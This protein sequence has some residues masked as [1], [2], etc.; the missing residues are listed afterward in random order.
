MKLKA[1]IFI[2]FMMLS[3]TV[4]SQYPPPAGQEG[5][6]AIHKD[7]L[8]FVN[9]ATG[10]TVQ[11]GPMDISEPGTGNASAGYPEFATSKADN[12]AVSLGDGGMA[13]LTF[14][15]PVVNG[16]GPDF[17]VFENGFQ[18]DFLELA[19]VEV[20]SN[21]I[22]FFRFA[23]VSL[24]QTDM[25][26]GAFGVLDATKI[27][28]LAGKYRVEYGVPFDLADLPDEPLL[29]KQ[30][31]THIRIADVVGSID[32]DYATYDSQGNKVN[33]PWPTPFESSGFDLDAVGVI[34]EATQSVRE[35]TV[36]REFIIYP[37]PVSDILFFDQKA[38]TEFEIRILDVTG[39]ILLVKKFTKTN[40]PSE[41]AIGQLENGFYLGTAFT[42]DAIHSFKFLKY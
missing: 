19:F 1:H 25:Q 34:H 32:D 13:I 14:E 24:T 33:E 23:A 16:D 28:N 38:F 9:W 2:A 8:V 18:D 42:G 12:Q 17:T 41:M 26:V 20:S 3:L 30:Q 4:V 6:D 39:K 21:G 7:S 31:V 11:R 29:D 15:N 22:D 36:D 27:H 40:Q 37:N 35:A 10:C 5:S